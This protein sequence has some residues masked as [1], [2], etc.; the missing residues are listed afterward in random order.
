MFTLIISFQ[1]KQLKRLILYHLSKDAK[2]KTKLC[3]SRYSFCVDVLMEIV[4]QVFAG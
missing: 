3:F 2:L 4:Q 1:L